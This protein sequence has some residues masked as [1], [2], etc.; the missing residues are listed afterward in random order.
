M[1]GE[2]VLASEKALKFLLIGTGEQLRASS[3]Y[4][5]IL[6]LVRNV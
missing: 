3:A 6:M 4:S 5:G 2:T 1:L